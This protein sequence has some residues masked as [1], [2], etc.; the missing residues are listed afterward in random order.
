MKKA[1]LISCFDWY[2]TRLK[3]I[4]ELL[5]GKE[6]EVV[7]LESDFDHIK[8][9][10][11]DLRYAECTYIHVPKYE[12]NISLS[13]IRSHLS[14]GNSIGK[15]IEQLKPDLIYCLI[16]P[17]NVAKYCV[18]YKEKSK[19]TQLIFDIIDLWPESMPLKKLRNNPLTKIW[20][21]WRDKSLR[22]ADYVF[23]ECDLYQEKLKYVLDPNKTS[24][25]YLF[26]DQN[27]EEKELVRKNINRKK[28]Q[29]CNIIKFAYLGSMNNIIDIDGICKVIKQFITSGY[30]CE[31]HAIGDGSNKDKFESDVKNTG[32][33]TFFYGLLF[34]E[35]EKIKL[36]SSCDFALN[37]M[38]DTSEVGL[39]IKSL[40]Y[41]SMGLPLIN[42]I[43]GDTWRFI[44]NEHIGINIGS[45]NDWVDNINLLVPRN[46]IVSFY[47]KH[48][49]EEAFINTV[50]GSLKDII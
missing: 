1:V 9:M 17:N 31:L 33:K 19:N 41:L 46:E 32:C 35:I 37:M 44:D 20:K 40:D 23:T 29:G 8:K 14:F 50:F 22:Y 15:K 28:N 39:T 6:Y 16:P 48:F 38:K 27:E 21:N 13:R 45:D 18:S 36:L 43:K 7:I 2:K 12:S 5:I 11:V 10:P 30:E 34:N 49:S 24:T 25:L 4:R 42:N 26:K 47:F 3:P